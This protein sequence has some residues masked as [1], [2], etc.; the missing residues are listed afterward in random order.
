ME[1]GPKV[2]LYFPNGIRADSLDDELLETMRQAGTIY[3]TFSLETASPRL[4]KF[5]KKNADIPKLTSIVKK[6]CDLNIITNLCIM[7]GFPTETLGEARETLEYYT[8]FDKVVLPYY[9]SVKYYPGTQIYRTASDFGIDIREDTYKAPYH[10]YEFQETPL[11]SGRDFEKLNQWYLRHVYL[12]PHRIANAMNIL[13]CHFSQEEIKD[14]FTVF[15]RRPI[16][17]VER[18]ILS[19]MGMAS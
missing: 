5:I 10:G 13:K 1:K 17:D 14:M 6:A 9:F 4:Q 19:P 8:Q 2:N 11:I 18:D 16:E 15:F 3:M 12:N 7:V